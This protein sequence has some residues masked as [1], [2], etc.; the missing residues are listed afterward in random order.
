MPVRLAQNP[1]PPSLSNASQSK[2]VDS[3]RE[4]LNQVLF[5]SGKQAKNSAKG[6]GKEKESKSKAKKRKE[7]DSWRLLSP[8]AVCH[9]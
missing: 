4:N 5:R 9:F 7:K 3:R 6:N 8:A 1:G 2:K